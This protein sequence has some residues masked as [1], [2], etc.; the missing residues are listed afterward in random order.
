M[1][2]QYILIIFTLLYIIFWAVIKI[3]YPF[4]NN[5]PVFHTYDYIRTL[6]GEPFIIQTNKPYKTK[7][8]DEK[9]VKTYNISE[10]SPIL[11]K[12]TDLL[13]CNYLSSEYV[14]YIILP[15][16]IQQLL[17]GQNEP[18]F[19]STYCITEYTVQP[20]NNNIEIVGND[21]VLGCITS[22]SVN[23]YIRSKQQDSVYK[24]N[25]CYFMDNLCVHREHDYK[26]ISRNLL[27]THEYNTRTYNTNVLC[28][29]I[30]KDGELF[31][32]IRPLIKY[33]TLFYAIPDKKVSRMHPSYCVVRLNTE[34]I[35]LFIDFFAV[36]DVFENKTLLFDIMVLPDIGNILSQLKEK[37]LYIYCLRNGE[38]ILGFYF[39][40][41]LRR[42]YDDKEA[43]TLS[44]VASVHNSQNNNLFYMGFLHALRQTI[45]INTD[46][47]MITIENIGHN[48]ILHH[49]WCQGKNSLYSVNSAYYSYNYV[50]P[51]SPINSNRCFLLL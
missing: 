10:C 12:I 50:Y 24:K 29:L 26:K 27:Q 13:Q 48:N 8:I 6:Y 35:D 15:N 22:R 36:N 41:D 5:Q 46:Y 45:H 32:G 39:I 16:D 21:K 2:L 37:L 34:N 19:I 47:K 7:Y 4:W 31:G 23:M 49:Y 11:K 9:M 40:K 30:K 20:D 18:S 25:I 51:S 42:H 1:I 28:S 38:N 14:D 3:K 33:N 44:L 43:K 17:T